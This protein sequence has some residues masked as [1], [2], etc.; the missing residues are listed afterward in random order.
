MPHDPAAKLLPKHFRLIRAI[1]DQRQLSIAARRLSMTQPA[2]SRMLAEIERIVGS[3]IFERHPKGMQTTPIGEV[4]AR[5][6][7]GVLFGIDETLREIDS[8]K[9]GKTGSVRVGAVTGAAV[10]FVVPALQ[11]LKGETRGADI[12]LEVAPSATLIASL[13][14]GDYDFVLSRLPPEI[15]PRQFDISRGRAEDIVF[16]ARPEHRLAGKTQLSLADLAGCTWI[17]QPPGTPMRQAVE[18]AYLSYEAALPQEII[19]TTSLLVMI[20]CLSSSDAIS[21][22]SRE[23]ADLIGATM[24]G[25]R[26]TT[27]DVRES[28]VVAPYH[29][30]SRKDQNISPLAQKLRGFVLR[31]LSDPASNHAQPL[32]SSSLS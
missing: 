20:A 8:F 22:I 28:I 6:A 24:H 17:I 18:D 25:G 4:L 2:A 9:S 11:A 3:P 31:A 32:A 7:T 23:V 29:V 15:D 12:R 10:A 14:A 30:I 19:I 21:P 1:A 26:L 13:L 16:L 5:R 27:L